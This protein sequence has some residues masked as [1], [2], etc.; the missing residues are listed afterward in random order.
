MP[1][2]LYSL[3]V[4]LLISSFRLRK[5]DS[6]FDKHSTNVI[7]G[8]FI[9][10][11]VLLHLLENFPYDGFLSGPLNTMVWS[12][13]SQLVV[14]MFFFISGYGI[15][16][17]VQSKPKY[18]KSILTNRFL[19][20]FLYTVVSLIP[21]I[22]YT[23][24]TGK[25]SYPVGRYFLALIGL[26]GIGNAHWFIFAILFC[27]LICGL[28]YLFNFKKNLIPTILVTIAIV[29]YIVIAC[30]VIKEHNRWW[31]TIISFPLG[32]F[33]ALFRDKINN[34]LKNKIVCISL[35][36]I[37]VAVVVVFRLVFE[38]LLGVPKIATMLFLN[39]FFCLFFVCL[40]K[41]FVLKSPILEYLGKA[42]FA[43][44]I[45][46]KLVIRIFLDYGAIPNQWLHYTVVFIG[47]FVV[48][49][50]FYYLYKVLDKNVTDKIVEFNRGLIK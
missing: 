49:I 44:F 7:K 33:A 47:Y 5:D 4:I 40:T 30:F 22:I 19:R 25:Y 31:D 37:S 11:I 15:I 28:I 13:V 8:F 24:A 12:V 38:K 36:A 14:S 29:V 50:P 46:H 45:M 23:I 16:L 35:M 18:A 26:K 32:M 9:L 27:Y 39:I 2:V 42:S 20:I 3:S 17:S 1:V 6:F 43:I 34:F 48:S 41:I 21:F 10:M